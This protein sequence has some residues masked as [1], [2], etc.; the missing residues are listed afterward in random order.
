ME[1]LIKELL[2]IFVIAALPIIALGWLVYRLA[3]GSKGDDL[4][5]K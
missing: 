3:K 2:Y 4:S 1:D 5:I